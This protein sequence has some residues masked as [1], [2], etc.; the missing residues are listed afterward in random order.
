[1]LGTIL[2]ALCLALLAGALDSLSHQLVL[3]ELNQEVKHC[4]G[5]LTPEPVPVTSEIDSLLLHR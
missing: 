1:M 3:G 2:H 4:A 5:C